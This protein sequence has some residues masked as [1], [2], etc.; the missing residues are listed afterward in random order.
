MRELFERYL[1]EGLYLKGWS[2]KTPTIYRRAFASLQRS[3]QEHGPE[4][5][6]GNSP[7]QP[8]QITKAQLQAWVV[9]MRLRGMSAAG[10]NIY[11]RAMNAFHVWL[12]AEGHLSEPVALA[13]L[14]VPVK[15]VTVFSVPD[16]RAFL[17]SRP[18]RQTYLR[19]WTLIALL[20]DTGCRIDEVLNLTT[21]AVDFQNLLL[22][23]DGKGGKQRK[24][25]FSEEMRRHLWRYC[26][27]RKSTRYLFGTRSGTRLTYRNAYRNIKACIQASG[28]EETKGTAHRVAHWCA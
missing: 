26:K 9:W 25:P 7:A 13:Q 20:L 8:C 6:R 16:V 12:R 17:A 18:K 11:I 1:H 19:T 3:L 28:S 23:V 10:C 22:T 27:A 21:E 2:P 15:A 24:V 14:K 4:H 5:V